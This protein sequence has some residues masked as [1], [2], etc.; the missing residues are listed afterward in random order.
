MKCNHDCF[1]CKKADC[2]RQTMSKWERK[3]MRGAHG[4]W[5]LENAAKIYTR[6]KSAGWTSYRIKAALDVTNSEFAKIKIAALRL[7]SKKRLL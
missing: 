1:H 2:T 7:A 4:E 3:V 5:D 6:M